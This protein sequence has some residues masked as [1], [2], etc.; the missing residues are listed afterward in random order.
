VAASAQSARELLDQG[1]RAYRNLDFDAAAGFLR[2]SLVAPAGQALPDS[3]RAR[4]L[5]Y[6]GATEV[7]RGR[8]DTA[9]AVFRRLLLLDPRARPDQLIFPPE[10]SNAYEAVRRVTKAVTIAVPAD[11]EIQLGDELYPVRLYATSFHDI[12]VVVTREDGRVLRPLYTGPISDSLVVRWDGLDSAGTMPAV[13]R[14]RVTAS[15]RDPQGRTLRQVQEPL[16]TRTRIPDT[17]PHPAP[18]DSGR[19]PERGSS[20]PALRALGAGLGAG[21]LVATLPSVIA[22]GTEA[23]GTRFVVAG[24]VSL[25]GIYGFLAQRPGRRIPANIAVNRAARETWERRRDQVAQE[26]ATR[27]RNVRLRVLAGTV[28]DSEQ[29]NP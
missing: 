12:A 16:E 27:R 4:A 6:L 24:A 8:R 2:R 17:L 26:N 3:A 9:A 10:V 25:T 7:F 20:G 23:S 21:V 5:T 13:G 19:L 15:S 29:D 22:N 11:T 1:I 18:P 28:I 14:F